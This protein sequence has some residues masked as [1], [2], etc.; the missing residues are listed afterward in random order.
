MSKITIIF[1]TR[2]PKAQKHA[3][4]RNSSV[5]NAIEKWSLVS[6]FRGRY[7]ENLTMYN[8]NNTFQ[9]LNGDENESFNMSTIL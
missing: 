7:L 1:K 6:T 8:T 5:E 9:R 4:F 2:C 3:K